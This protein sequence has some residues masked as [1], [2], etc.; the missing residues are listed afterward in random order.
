MVRLSDDTI[1]A[2]ATPPGRGALAIVRLSGA[3]AHDVARR[4]THPWPATHR[5][6][7]LAEIRDPDTGA[8]IDQVI[9]ISYAGP[10]SY[11]GEPMVEL[12]GHGGPLSAAAIVDVLGRQGARLAEPG[13]FTLRAVLNGRMDLLQAEAV[14]DV[15]DAPTEAGRRAALTHLA[16]GLSRHVESLRSRILEL[17]AL[18]AYEIDFPEEDD[19]PISPARIDAAVT[20]LS[21]DIARL[22]ATSSMG[23]VL[24]TGAVVVIVGRPNVGKS[25]LFNALLGYRRAIVSDIPGTTR[26]A[27]EALVETGRWPLRL[28]DTAGLRESGDVIEQEGIEISRRYMEG[29][30]VALVCD[31][32]VA[33]LQ[34]A[35]DAVRAHTAAPLVAVRTKS[36]LGA[37]PA[38]A[39]PP[40][41]VD[42]FV[43]VS[44]H[45][46]TGLDALTRAVD[47]V[48][49]SRYR[50]AIAPDL[51]VLVRARQRGAL[52]DAARELAQFQEAR[53][54][55]SVPVAIAAVHVRQAAHALESLIGAVDVEDVLTRV[56]SSF[57]IGK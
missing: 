47:S 41:S 57:C 18:L 6:A 29:A 4:V 50:G 9:A 20:A 25:A 22:L 30:H 8:L 55:G 49:E 2:I 11:T 24:R 36:D 7:T 3:R 31:D 19:G 33:K 34:T 45:A 27:I 56:F 54:S 32:D 23:E 42:A 28:V 26:D 10:R 52:E 43:E 46:G 53:R 39:A 14:A 21:D 17:E 12:T 35:V 40:H 16:G 51:P 15:V 37:L 13:E 48:L 38:A 5:H 44:A 1:V